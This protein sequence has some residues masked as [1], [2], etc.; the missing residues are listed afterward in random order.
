MKKTLL[1]EILKNTPAF[2]AEFI[3]THDVKV[4]YSTM[5]PKFTV[6]HATGYADTYRVTDAGVLNRALVDRLFSGIPAKYVKF[7]G[8]TRVM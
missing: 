7:N 4:F 1:A 2:R 6:L 8:Y 5:L 3:L